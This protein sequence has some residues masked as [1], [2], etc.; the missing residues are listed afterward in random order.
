[1]FKDSIQIAVVPARFDSASHPRALSSHLWKNGHL[2]CIDTSQ[3]KPGTIYGKVI[4][5]QFDPQTVLQWLGFCSTRH[6]KLCY[7]NVKVPHLKLVDCEDGSI[8]LAPKEARYVALSYVWGTSKEV[9]LDGNLSGQEKDSRRCLA[10]PLN[11]PKVVGDAIQV[12]KQLQFRYLWI[13]KYCI[14]Q[15]NSEDKH[16]QI[17]QMD[18]I[19]KGSELTIIAASGLDENSGLPGVGTTSRTPQPAVSIGN[20]SII[21]TMPHPHHTIKTSK[22]MTRAWTL[23]E[24][25]L[26]RRRLVFT[27]DQIYFECNAMNCFESLAAPLELLHTK[28]NDRFYAFMRSGLFTGRDEGLWRQIFGNPF[29]DF[30]DRDNTWSEDFRKYL[31]LAT[32]YTSRNLSFDDDSLKGFAGI[33]RHLETSKYPISQVVGIPYLHPSVFPDDTLPFDCLVAA[34]CWRHIECCWSGG[35]KIRRRSAFPSWTWAGWAGAVSWTDL[36]TDQEMDLVSLVDDLQCEMDDGTLVPLP[37][38]Q[39]K[40]RVGRLQNPQALRF[41]AWFIHPSVIR[42]DDSA[43][44]PEW[45]IYSFSL[46]LHISE[47]DGSPRRFLEALMSGRVECIFVAKGLYNSYFLIIEPQR[48]YAGQL[49]SSRRI[50]SAEAIWYAGYHGI[51]KRFANMSFTSVKQN[52]RLV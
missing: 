1:M 3:T 47:F 14:D 26:S 49:P 29:G 17:Q 20:M 48:Q 38:H 37:V 32:N 2:S 51:T 30:D 34:L 6:R 25:V 10:L 41:S 5:R 44:T 31:I 15:S 40:E 45:W 43:T 8:I 39:P 42:L 35:G 11:L 13:D 52:V 33:T 7:A 27:N 12:T 36:F 23:Q 21:S 9:S 18:L 50:G 46:N 19:Y 24:S 28:T 22:W 16:E 4:P